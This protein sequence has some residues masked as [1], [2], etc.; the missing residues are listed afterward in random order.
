MQSYNIYHTLAHP[1]KTGYF[2]PRIKCFLVLLLLMIVDISPIPILEAIFMIIQ[3][4]R[5]R[6]FKDL[7]DKITLDRAR[8]IKTILTI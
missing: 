2:S 8:Q 5:S 4:F 7:V 6:C 3:L 1:Q